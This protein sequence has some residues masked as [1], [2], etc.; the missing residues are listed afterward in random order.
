MYIEIFQYRVEVGTEIKEYHEWILLA[1]V[2]VE[3]RWIHES[4]VYGETCAEEVVGQFELK[5]LDANCFTG[6]PRV[7]CDTGRPVANRA[8]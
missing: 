4:A 2:L 7:D 3:T 8:K 6:K 5:G 1:G